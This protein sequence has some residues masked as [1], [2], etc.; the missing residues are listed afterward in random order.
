MRLFLV[1]FLAA[2]GQTDDVFLPGD[3]PDVTTTPFDTG[4]PFSDVSTPSEAEAGPIYVG[5]PLTCGSCT[6]DGTLYACLEGACA[7]P[8]PIEAGTNADASDDADADAASDASASCGKNAICQELPIECL[9]KPTCAC[10][11]KATGLGCSVATN[12][13][14]FILSCQ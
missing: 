11:E 4:G 3:T 8:P 9:P 7:K 13:S 14:G 6:C 2:C 1:C 10:I 5:G 12:G